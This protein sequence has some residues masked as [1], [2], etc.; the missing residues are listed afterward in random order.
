VHEA[1]TGAA[2]DR[3]PRRGPYEVV[4]KYKLVRPCYRKRSKSP[5]QADAAPIFRTK[6]AAAEL[7]HPPKPLNLQP[8]ADPGPLRKGARPASRP[9]GARRPPGQPYT[10]IQRP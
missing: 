2:K 3:L 9:R 1:P 5:L 8:E 6:E 4:R 7:H 10:Q